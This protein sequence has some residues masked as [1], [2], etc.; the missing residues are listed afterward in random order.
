MSMSKHVYAKF[1][2]GQGATIVAGFFLIA[3]LLF[4]RP[5]QALPR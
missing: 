1:A 4:A 3:S 2:G 5:M